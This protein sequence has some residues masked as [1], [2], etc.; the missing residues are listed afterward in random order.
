MDASPGNNTNNVQN[1]TNQLNPAYSGFSFGGTQSPEG[2]MNMYSPA[3]SQYG[4]MN[5]QFSPQSY[6]F[7]SYG[8]TAYGG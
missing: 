7:S 5:N 8:G 6:P 2:F 4:Q 3:S 1:N